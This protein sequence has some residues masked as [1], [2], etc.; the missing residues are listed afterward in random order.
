MMRTRNMLLWVVLLVLALVLAACGG[1]DDD[2]KNDEASGAVDPTATSVS[3]GTDL[4]A[5]SDM[6]GCSDPNDEECPAPIQLPLD[7]TATAADVSISYAAR[8]F[9]AVTE[10]LPDEMLIQITPSANNRYTEEAVFSVYFAE[11]VEAALAGLVEPDSAEWRT[12]TLTGTIAVSKD[13]TQDPVVTTSIGAFDTGDGRVIVLQAVTTE[14]YG[15][16]LWAQV[17]AEMLDTLVVGG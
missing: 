11:S 13:E 9:D 17:Y 1:G 5:I 3:F 12:D 6:P 14:M 4:G 10:G 2:K 8:Y 16:D 7:G 15:W